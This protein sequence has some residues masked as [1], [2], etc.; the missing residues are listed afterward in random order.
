M[1]ASIISEKLLE[2]EA[3]IGSEDTGKLKE[4]KDGWASNIKINRNW[5][6]LSGEASPIFS[7]AIE[8]F[9]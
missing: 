4:A 1:V 5:F 6:Q 2:H 3:K 8:N 9:E 7:H